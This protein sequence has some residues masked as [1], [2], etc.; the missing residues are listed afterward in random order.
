MLFSNFN[1]LLQFP[2]L[3]GGLYGFFW[4]MVF[5]LV[6][7]FLRTPKKQQAR[8]YLIVHYQGIRNLMLR[9]QFQFIVFLPRHGMVSLSVICLLTMLQ[10]LQD[11]VF[12]VGLKGGLAA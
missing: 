3:L 6:S 4:L 10:L 9:S 8:I 1:I 11:R 5:R 2:I 7:T 12:E